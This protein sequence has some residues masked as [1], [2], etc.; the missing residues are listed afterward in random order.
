[1]LIKVFKKLLFLLPLLLFIFPFYVIAQSPEK[2]GF[3]ISPFSF[4]Y[5]A[6]PGDKINGVLRVENINNEEINV[7]IDPE[8]LIAY[9]QDGQVALT[10]E[11]PTFSLKKWVVLNKKSERIKPKDFAYF[12][13][14]INV[15]KDIE[16]GTHYGALTVTFTGDKKEFT[17]TGADIIQ[18][19]SAI[20]LLRLPG[21]T[22]E[23]LRLTYFQTDKFFYTDTNVKFSALLEN[24]GNVHVKPFGQILIFDLFGNKIKEINLTGKNVLPNNK[25]IFEE[26]VNIEPISYFR[27]E[28]NMF[29]GSTSQKTIFAQTNFIGINWPVL[30]K[31][32]LILLAVIVF[33][34]IFRKRINKAVK[35]LLKGD[36]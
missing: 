21:D 31:Y 8:S 25:R 6:K 29:Y 3:S 34:I 24:K 11:E 7:T 12:D 28:L 14:T 27:A 1:M 10:E 9:G 13:F 20:V 5:D 22:V 4:E 35:I 15:P 23:D 19:S 2:I 18:K 16:P 17:S 32:L 33:Y 30:S 26:D 36:K